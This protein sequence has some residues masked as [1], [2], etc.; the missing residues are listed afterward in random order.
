MQSSSLIPH[1][2]LQAAL[3]E[4]RLGNPV[5]FPTETV[6][7]LGADARNPQ[8][9]KRLYEIKGRPAQRPLTVHL[10]HVEEITSW[11]AAIPPA[12]SK[13]IERFCP[14]PLTLILPKAEQVSDL[15]TAG[16]PNVGIRLPGNDMALQLID[17]FGSGLVAPS[18]N[19]S[20]Y[21][22]PTT[23][24]HVRRE[25]GQD[26]KV[27]LDGGPCDLG[28]ESTI[29]D[30]SS[31]TPRLLRLGVIT[32][33]MLEDTLGQ[34]IAV[35][36]NSAATSERHYHPRTPARLIASAALDEALQEALGAGQPVGL[37]CRPP[38]RLPESQLLQ[39]A[40]LP[41]EPAAYGA[42]LYEHLRYMDTKKLAQILIEDVPLS[43]SW[44][45]IRQR[46]LG[47][48]A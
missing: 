40:I 19:R 9:I 29:I 33:T 8:A 11:V 2:I 4:L 13:L 24:E 16:Q 26:V 37:I 48:T 25:F 36:P 23:A 15:V 10:A 30:L 42:R 31:A 34:E 43:A 12:A 22:S 7:G 38:R 21:L 28:I 3:A 1:D 39:A 18:A 47:V 6:Y 27:I 41:D 44:E 46:L 20:G 5:A 17:A 45:A 32:R 14:G 35:P